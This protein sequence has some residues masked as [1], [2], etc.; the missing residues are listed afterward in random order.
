MNPKN[1]STEKRKFPASF[2]GVSLRVLC[3]SMLLAAQTEFASG[4]LLSI[5]FEQNGAST[6]QAG[7][8]AFLGNASQ[9]G[10]TTL[11][12]STANGTVNVSMNSQVDANDLGGGYLFRSPAISN[13]G[14]LTTAD[15]YNSFVFNNST[16]GFQIN[17][18]TSI[19]LTLS[20]AGI[21][22][23]TAYLLTF[24]SWDNR[25]GGES[26][27]PSGHQVTFAGASG[28]TG[29]TSL[30]SHFG[31][32]PTADNTY[33][34]TQSYTSSASGNLT[35]TISD[36]Y[37]ALSN[38]DARSG[39]RLNGFVLAVP[40]PSTVTLSLLSLTALMARRRRNARS[41]VL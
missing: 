31:T 28:T 36:F 40:E 24:Y 20:G 41:P 22:P 7:F 9:T 27:S 39:V 10:V 13:G 16:N 1:N 14:S 21:S 33:A 17:Q 5:Q 18:T 25:S 30:V 3:M 35:F 8:S 2:W 26:F 12:F 38:G 32:A 6:T 37:G 4:A 29:T 23:S 19:T 34:V 15:L 11:P